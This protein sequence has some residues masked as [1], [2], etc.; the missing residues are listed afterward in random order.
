MDNTSTS[1]FNVS[2]FLPP[3]E[4]DMECNMSTGCD[5]HDANQTDHLFDRIL[6]I[7]EITFTCFDILNL[8]GNA[9]LMLLIYKAS[10]KMEASGRIL[11]NQAVADAGNGLSWLILY[12]VMYTNPH[13]DILQTTLLVQRVVMSIL[14]SESGLSLAMTLFALHIAICNPVSYKIYLEHKHITVFIAVSWLVVIGTWNLVFVADNYFILERDSIMVKLN[15]TEQN[16]WFASL[17][18]TMNVILPLVTVIISYTRICLFMRKEENTSITSASAT[19][20]YVRQ[21]K[22]ILLVSITYMVTFVP[23]FIFDLFKGYFE[24]GNAVVLF[25]SGTSLAFLN[26]V[27]H[28]FKLPLFLLAFPSY[29]RVPYR[30]FFQRQRSEDLS[31]ASDH[32]ERFRSE[33]SNGT[34]HDDG[35]FQQNFEDPRSTPIQMD[36]TIEVKGN[37]GRVNHAFTKTC[38]V[39]HDDT[40]TTN[41]TVDDITFSTNDDV[42]PNVISNKPFS[43]QAAPLDGSE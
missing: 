19:M 8:L 5:V 6:H 9:L 3:Q 28:A 36:G 38:S 25:I 33:K 18:L 23:L 15:V 32:R 34:K 39:N 11:M 10:T 14:Y 42:I 26:Y 20:R 21:A 43:R 12:G 37:I 41:G 22:G 40:A 27:Y 13:R 24:S 2:D 4:T 31:V 1:S 35:G 29:R 7:T 16:I 30:L 17:T